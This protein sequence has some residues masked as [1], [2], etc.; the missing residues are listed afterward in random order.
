MPRLRQGEWQPPKVM[1]QFVPCT[2]SCGVP[3]AGPKDA[4]PAWPSRLCKTLASL[5]M[6]LVSFYFTTL[7][8]WQRLDLSGIVDDEPMEM[9]LPPPR[10]GQASSA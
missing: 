1:K 5:P 9:G 7:S 8:D 10:S 2:L 3:L 6:I 4:R